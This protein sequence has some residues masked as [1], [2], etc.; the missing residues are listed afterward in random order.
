MKPTKNYIF[1]FESLSANNPTGK[2]T[3]ILKILILLGVLSLCGFA[4]WFGEHISMGQPVFFWLLCFAI[5]YRIVRVLNEWYNYFYIKN[6]SPLVTDANLKTVDILTTYFPGEPKEMTKNTLLAM[7]KIK[8]PHENF[9]CD[10]ANDDE[11]RNFCL[12]NDI[13]HITRDNLQEAKAGNINNALKFATGEFCFILDPDHVPHPD[14]LDKIIP[15][16]GDPEIG[17]VQIVQGYYNSENSLIAKGAAQQTYQFYG[18]IMMSMS[19][20]GTTQAIGANCCFRRKALES[21]GGHAPG[22][23]EDLH[24]SMLLHAKG[25]KSL[26]I[27]EVLTKGLVPEDYHGYFKQ[28]LKWSKGSFDLLF[29]V[30]PKIF[31]RLNFRQKLH[32]LSQPQYYLF[33]V[34]NLIEIL[35]PIFSLLFFF[36]PW[37]IDI[38]YFFL[39]LSPFI[40]F[41]VLIHIYAQ[42]W[43]LEEKEV[44]FHFLGGVLRNA[45]W[46][47]YV[48]G[49]IFSVL[50]ISVKYL[51]TPKENR[52][53][54]QVKFVIP[55]LLFASLCLFSIVYG[56]YHDLTPF[57]LFMSGFALTNF[58][59]L[60]IS[61]FF[62]FPRFNI[63]KAPP[64][65]KISVRSF[66]NYGEKHFWILKH[67]MY[68]FMRQKSILV[69]SILLVIP[70]SLMFFTNPIKT[71]EKV[72]TGDFFMYA[73]ENENHS[74]NSNTRI[75]PIEI[76]SSLRIENI[77]WPNTEHNLFIQIVFKNSSASF[78]DDINYGN[79]DKVINE[80][81]LKLK[82]YDQQFFI[83]VKF[84][85]NLLIT[86]NINNRE[87]SFRIKT[88]YDRLLDIFKDNNCYTAIWVWPVLKKPNGE[89]LMPNDDNYDWLII[90]AFDSN[91]S[92]FSSYI[93][94]SDANLLKPIIIDA[95]EIKPGMLG[96]R[97]FNKF[98][99]NLNVAGLITNS[100]K[101]ENSFREYSRANKGKKVLPIAY[102]R[103]AYD[104]MERNKMSLDT[105]KGICYDPYNLEIKE[106]SILN[107]LRL[108][109]DFNRISSIGAN[110]LRVYSKDIYF[111]NILASANR[112]NL[113]LMVGVEIPF[114]LDFYS[115]KKGVDILQKELLNEIIKYG[116]NEQIL[117]WNL[118][119]DIIGHIEN[120]FAKPYSQK[121]I[122]AYFSFLND[123]TSKIYKTN[124]KINFTFS[125]P[126]SL[127]NID[128]ILDNTN[129]LSPNLFVGF[130]VFYK[131]HFEYLRQKIMDS[132]L[133]SKV[134][135]TAFGPDGYWDSKLTLRSN[136]HQPIEAND[137]NKANDYVHKWNDYLK[138]S[139][140]AIPG[141]FVYRWK[142]HP[143]DFTTWMGVNSVLNTKKLSYYS[144][145]NLWLNQSA[146]M[147]E[148]GNYNLVYN[149]LRI[150]PFSE[151]ANFYLARNY[152]I[153][154]TLGDN[155]QANWVLSKISKN[156]DAYTQFLGQEVKQIIPE[157]LSEGQYRM[158]VYISD[159][160]ESS[161]SLS[162][163]FAVI[164]E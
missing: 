91:L 86:N 120:H 61:S 30:L 142:D 68:R 111:R 1:S 149:G 71:M 40:S 116:N 44:G 2:E 37:K 27:P 162:A 92:D 130:N 128:L 26:Y 101:Q 11:L 133:K 45:T 22:L 6:R 12:E 137:L 79:Y 77:E 106:K 93:K 104:S 31:Q 59:F 70:F 85:S 7:K 161:I 60:F 110:S 80:L 57:S 164:N 58:I 154:N 134:V 20:L 75:V 13:R 74:T 83:S 157:E 98:A 126:F 81:C 135:I 87:T 9:L 36:V 102:S 143:D 73:S 147:P 158:H 118:G 3:L 18:P 10:E 89:Y 105:I 127:N 153:A 139:S 82:E 129:F 151:D 108:D 99:E 163:P 39:A 119:D 88:A 28:Q 124:P 17:F 52:I 67:N 65:R 144:L 140:L 121:V 69:A 109:E 62:A 15:Q 115:D 25:W 100:K 35:T 84:D 41:S 54:N 123:L 32:Y 38:F 34:V 14:L 51:P 76:S 94:S 43:V 53:G 46:F 19:Q 113:K 5:L 136:L 146:P 64:E 33:G 4:F 138:D 155:L 114:D 150:I 131:K 132:E 63:G 21:I 107:K 72:N 56:L 103:F 50:N 152:E 117:F 96:K 141:G 49:L 95:S 29:G 159:S 125:I 16:F 145:R 23:A 97:T 112:F 24:T 90:K 160:S 55:N 66:I 8:Y 42:K 47:I 48:L 148:P 122:L 78:F 156:G